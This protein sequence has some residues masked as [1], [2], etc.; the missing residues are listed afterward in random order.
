MAHDYENMHDLEDLSD[1]ELRSL[2]EERLAAHEGL[3]AADITVTV[4]DREVRL[5][6]RVGTEAERRIADHVVTDVVGMQ[7]V[8]NY[9][10]VDELRRAESPEAADDSLADEDAR[11]GLLLGDRPVPQSPEADHLEE[12]LDARLYGTADVHKAIESGTAWIPPSEPTPEG[13]S[14]GDVSPGGRSADH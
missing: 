5:D 1:Q 9:L 10:V 2:V 8:R 6:G 7:R 11:A 4:R 12:N 13:L 14:G 3:D